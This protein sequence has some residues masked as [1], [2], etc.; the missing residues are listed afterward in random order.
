MS[1]INDGL[2]DLRKRYPSW[3]LSADWAARSSAG[4][5]RV[6]RAERDGVTVTAFNPDTLAARM[7]DADR[8]RTPG[9]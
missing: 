6:L 3:S 4:D 8:E 2:D 5:Y 9:R 7:A 1:L